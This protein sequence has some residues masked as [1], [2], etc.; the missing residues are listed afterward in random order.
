MSL[1]RRPFLALALVA[2]L[3]SSTAASLATAT[4]WASEFF[5]CSSCVVTFAP[6][7]VDSEAS[8]AAL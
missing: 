4:D 7:A 8:I 6:A 1:Q 2:G 3:V 5:M